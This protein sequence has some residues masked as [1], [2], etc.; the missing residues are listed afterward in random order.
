MSPI[1]Y[2]LGELYDDGA[3]LDVPRKP[4]ISD[5]GFDR[6]EWAK[7]GV[8][9]DRSLATLAIVQALQH[10]CESPI[11]VQLGLQLILLLGDNYEVIPQFKFQRFRM[12]FAIAH[13][14][15]AFLFVE[16]DG[17]KFHSTPEQI[18]NDR[19]KDAAAKAAGIPLLRFTGKE[20]HFSAEACA[21]YVRDTLE[22]LG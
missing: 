11:E 8:C 3:Q 20:I 10:R 2:E 18:A 14:S 15:R 17:E 19:R 6:D 16:C 4:A 22:P 7:L 5:F 12:D 9:L 13:K 21:L 1:D